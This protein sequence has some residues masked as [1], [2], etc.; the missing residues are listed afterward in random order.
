MIPATGATLTLQRRFASPP[1]T[2]YRAWIDPVLYVRW[3]APEGLDVTLFERDLRAGGAYRIEM[4]GGDQ[5][6]I[7]TGR[8]LEIDPPRRLA[9]TWRWQHGKQ[10][11]MKIVIDLRPDGDGTE[12]TLTQTGLLDQTDAD[13]HRRGWTSVLDRL[14]GSLGQ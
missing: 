4:R 3:G 10:G 5:H 1:D 9:M 8:Y 6:H 2:V 14:A 11:D 13:N 7:V 12:L